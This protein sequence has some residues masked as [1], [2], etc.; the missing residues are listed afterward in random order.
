MFDPMGFLD[1]ASKNCWG[2][3]SEA[4]QR[5]AMSRLYYATF[6]VCRDFFAR[7]RSVS[8]GKGSKVH[9]DV[10]TALES[11]DENLAD[12]LNQL[13]EARNSADYDLYM[14]IDTLMGD[15]ESH[16]AS[17]LKIIGRVQKEKHI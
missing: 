5:T 11:I 13:R 14:T 7:D 8:F 15:Y 16:R 6:L 12:D 10:I 4:E 3:C 1:V 17:A 2:T 9:G